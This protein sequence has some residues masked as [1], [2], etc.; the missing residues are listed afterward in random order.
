MLNLAK[1]Q[2]KIISWIQTIFKPKNEP[3][4]QTFKSIENQLV[5]FAKYPIKI[6]SILGATKLLKITSTF[7]AKIYWKSLQF[8]GQKSTEINLIFGAKIYLISPLFLR[9]K[10]IENQLVSLAKN[11]VKI[12]SILL[13][14]LKSLQFLGQK[15][16]KITSTENHFNFLGKNPLKSL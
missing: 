1:L 7:G 9:Q 2:A 16:I 3:I 4:K 10:S 14:S 13:H 11:P 6:T 8:F 5:S 15:S 12:N